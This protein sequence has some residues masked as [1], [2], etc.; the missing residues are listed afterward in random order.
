[1]EK[2]TVPVILAAILCITVSCSKMEPQLYSGPFD[3]VTV[4]YAAAYNNLSGGISGTSESSC[5]DLQD[6]CKG[7]IPLKTDHRAL[8]AFCHN[9]YKDSSSDF[10]TPNSPVLIRIYEDNDKAVLDTVKVYPSSTVSANAVTLGNVLGTVEK[11][12]QSSHYGLIFDSHG[13]GWLPSQY[14]SDS[15][16]AP[17]PSSVGAQFDKS[18]TYTYEIDI[19]DFADAIPMHLDYMIFDACLMGGI[20]VAYQFRKKCDRIVFSPAEIFTEGM[21]YLNA[22]ERLV[23]AEPDLE[24]VC[25][26]YMENYESGATISCVDCSVL[27]RLAAAVK[28]IADTYGDDIWSIRRS[29]VQKFYT[30]SHPWFYDMRDILANLAPDSP[31]LEAVDDLLA[32]AVLYKDYTPEFGRGTNYYIK[33]ERYSGLSMY[34]PCTGYTDLNTYYKTLDW[35]ADTGLVK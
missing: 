9:T 3:S 25:K 10:T 29:D 24:G 18:Y 32:E 6:L 12:Y 20:E 4:L 15:K 5:S 13:T 2:R 31:E 34:L 35:C 7:K 22:A 30:G 28:K 1:M 17:A 16:P 21:Y 27:E 14:Y 26:D 23:C 8:L 19:K 33:I 11:E